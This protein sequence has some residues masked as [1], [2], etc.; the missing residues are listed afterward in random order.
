MRPQ[1]VFFRALHPPN[2]PS[3]NRS[4]LDHDRRSPNLAS[5]IADAAQPPRMRF[6]P[7]LAGPRREANQ[8]TY[9]FATPQ[10]AGPA[11]E[12]SVPA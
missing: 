7:I 4:H 2:V 11:A 5:G 10:T 9:H 8:V 1:L 6:A 3:R 12:S